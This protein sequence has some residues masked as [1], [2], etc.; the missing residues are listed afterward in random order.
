MGGGVSVTDS[1]D[2]DGELRLERG[3]SNKESIDV[4]LSDKFCT[5]SSI[6]RTTVLN[7]H[8]S[9]DVSVHLFGQPRS[10]V[11][12]S[13][14]GDSWG[15]G[16]A[17]ANGPDG[18]ISDD[19]VAPLVDRALDGTELSGE[20][21]VGFASLSLLESLTAAEDCLEAASLGLGD[22]LGNDIVTLAEELSAL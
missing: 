6:G 10:D 16:L 13:F 15:C 3:T 2:D 5:V 14:L 9:G 21:R 4:W 22:L 11:G 18:L 8:G 20:D 1:L 7:S 12:V 19:N 17:S